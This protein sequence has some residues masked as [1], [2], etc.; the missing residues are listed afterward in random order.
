[1]EESTISMVLV[2]EDDA[3][4][5]H[6]IYY[7]SRGLVGLELHYSPIEKLALVAVH[8][9]QRLRHY[10][11]LRKTF[12]LVAVNPFQFV[13]SRR[14][15]GGKYNRWIVILQEFNME[16]LST[17]SKKSLVFMELILEL[18]CKE[19][20]VYEENFPDEHLFLISSQDPWYGDIII[21]LHTSKITAA[22]SKDEH[23]KL[24]HLAKK[25][26]FI[27]DTLYCRGVDSILRRCLTLEEAESILND[28]HNGAC[29]GHLSGLA[30]T[31]NFLR[32]G[33]FWPSIFKDCI[34]V[35]KGFHPCQIYTRKMCAHPTL[36]FPIINVSPFTKW[37]IDFITCNPSSAVNHKYII[38]AV[39]YFTK[40]VEAMP[41]YKN[42]SEATTLFLF[43]QVISRFGIP[44][45]I[46]T[47]HGSH[48]QNQLMTKLALK[49]GFQQEH[50][51]PYYPQANG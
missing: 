5:D 50:S 35:V 20:I 10:I 44:R 24:H 38:M 30:T 16:F 19:A 22:F 3:L 41:T 45:E 21:Y 36:I 13:L 11:L 31:Q 32:A 12:I 40:W 9:V 51:S 7:L 23:R 27:G 43:N 49:L 37:G 18:P 2:Q 14:V 46:L 34:K 28:C 6:V 42:D 48:F 15:I 25:Y 29:G 8:V 1:M 4:I 39:D 47:D 26:V 17:K 33:Y